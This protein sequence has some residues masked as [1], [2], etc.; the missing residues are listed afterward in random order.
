MNGDEAICSL[1]ALQLVNI[2]SSV[3]FVEAVVESDIHILCHI[4]R[5]LCV[6]GC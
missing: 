3:T 1:P 4:P 2:Y 6:A 5:A